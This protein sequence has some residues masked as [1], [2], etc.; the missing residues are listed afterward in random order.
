MTHNDLH[1]GNV[2]INLEFKGNS[3]VTLID[4]ESMYLSVISPSSNHADVM[5][6]TEKLESILGCNEGDQIIHHFKTAYEKG[7]RDTLKYFITS[8]LLEDFIIVLR[9]QSS[10]KAKP[11]LFQQDPSEM[12]SDLSFY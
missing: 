8:N 10:P 5:F 3:A 11:V 2:F 12:S 6:F 4:L 1:P 7:L 9:S